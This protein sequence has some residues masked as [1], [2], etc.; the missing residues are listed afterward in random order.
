MLFGRY[1]ILSDRRIPF[2]EAEQGYLKCGIQ[3][4]N[5]QLQNEFADLQLLNFKYKFVLL[6]PLEV[7]SLCSQ[8]HAFAKKRERLF[9]DARS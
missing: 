8:K 9:M 3:S 2:A 7:K 1:I 6:E 4:T 5:N